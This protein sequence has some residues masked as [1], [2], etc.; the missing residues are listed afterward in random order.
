MLR[1][2]AAYGVD[3]L[4]ALPAVLML[5]VSVCMPLFR[6]KQH[7]C[8][9]ICPYGSAQSLLA[10]LPTPKVQVSARIARIM[11]Q[12]RQGVLMLL[13]FTL[14][15]GT[16]AWLLDYEPFTAFTPSVAA[17]AVLVLAGTFALASLFVPHL[18]C[19][20]LC[21]LGAL[22][23]LAEHDTPGLYDA[24]RK[25]HAGRQPSG[26]APASHKP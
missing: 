8:A 24:L 16:G 2:W 26:Q 21:P 20:S 14:W 12:V 17:P 3:P 6:H 19:R 18:W 22:L 9:W 5:L 10:A 11:G 13:L 15:M 25:P 1:G 23:Q 7:Y 4:L